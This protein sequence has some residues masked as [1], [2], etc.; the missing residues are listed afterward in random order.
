MEKLYIW[1]V[2]TIIWNLG[3]GKESTTI[4]VAPNFKAVLNKFQDVIDNPNAEIKY[5]NKVAE[6]A[7]VL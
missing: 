6:V 7:G 3:E 1:E 2:G 4:W 5:I